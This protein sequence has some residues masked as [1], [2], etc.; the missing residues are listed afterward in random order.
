[1]VEAKSIGA[2]FVLLIAAVLSPK[3]LKSLAA[4]AKSLGLGVLM[5]VHNREELI[6]S[7]CPD[8]DLVGVNNRNLKTF[9]V[10]LQTS[11]DLAEDIPREFVRISESGIKSVEDILSLRSYG[12]DGFLIGES[13]MKTKD[14]GGAC[15]N[16]IQKLEAL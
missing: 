14:P 3:E 15:K 12:Y 6:S 13:F 11:M 1:L 10:S 16:F 4:F 8:L 2:D 7:I 5:E 9:Q